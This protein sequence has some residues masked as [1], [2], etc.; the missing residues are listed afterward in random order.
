MTGEPLRKKAKAIFD[1]LNPDKPNPQEGHEELPS[2]SQTQVDIPTDGQSQSAAQ[3]DTLRGEEEEE[4]TQGTVRIR[5]K[6]KASALGEAGHVRPLKTPRSAYQQ[7]DA[8]TRELGSPGAPQPEKQQP[9][10]KSQKRGALIGKPDTDSAF[11]KAI[12]STK[13]GKRVEDNFDREFNQL[14]IS[15][16]DIL[17]EEPEQQ[18]A[19]LANFG[20][21]VEVRGNFMVIVEMEVPQVNKRPYS[22]HQAEWLNTPNFKKFKKVG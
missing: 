11:L 5:S 2:I 20:D 19:V 4:E 18:W 22:I 21:E 17:R 10:I 6:R 16:P 7:I 1:E 12:A 9:P 8:V 15:K 13:R 3:L 14:K